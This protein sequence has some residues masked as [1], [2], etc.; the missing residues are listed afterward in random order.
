L[1]QLTC[2]A[3]LFDLDG[4]LVDSTPCVM[5]VW[6]GWALE[7]GREPEAVIHTAHGRRAIETLRLVAPEMDAE[8]E[9]R[10][11]ERRELEDMDGLVVFPGARELL[12]SLPPER[13]TVVT[14]GTRALATKRMTVAGLPVPPRMVTADDVTLGKPDPAPFLKAAALLGLPPED[15]VVIED[16]PS[17]IRA[18]LAAG[19]KCIAVPTTYTHAE[20]AEADVVL[21]AIA[22][23]TASVEGGVIRLT[24]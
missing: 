9:L 8:A 20:I 5:R 12:A 13:W 6:R 11:V 15:C 14:S 24:W 22:Q 10:E 3:V 4:V 1:G 21:D 18:A 23:L 2:K 19:M 17:G 7:H 16:A